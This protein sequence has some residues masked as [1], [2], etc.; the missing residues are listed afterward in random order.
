VL[1]N[2]KDLVIHKRGTLWI[3]D[4][5]IFREWQTEAK[6]AIRGPHFAGLLEVVERANRPG[7]KWSADD[8]G[9]LW[10]IL[11]SSRPYRARR[12]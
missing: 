1:H 11:I 10:A 9:M 12:R 7:G 8:F 5:D 6:E 2:I 4:F 3:K